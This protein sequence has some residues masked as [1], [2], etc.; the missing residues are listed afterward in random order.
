MKHIQTI[1]AYSDA[2]LSFR[3]NHAIKIGIMLMVL[4]S[5]QLQT[6]FAQSVV[7]GKV[8]DA[9]GG[10]LPGVS[11][12]LVGSATGTTTNSSGEFSLK[13]PSDG[14]LE[15][16]YIGYL[17]ATV[18]IDGKSVINTILSENNQNLNEVS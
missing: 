18:P 3:F 9:T 14:T 16:S 17:K 5:L 1:F 10:V 13:A 8:T 2:R 15:F 11:V 4:L 6:A 12:K 7:K